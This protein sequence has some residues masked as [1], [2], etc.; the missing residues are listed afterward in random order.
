MDKANC[1]AGVTGG[2]GG[3]LEA[4]IELVEVWEEACEC[5]EPREHWLVVED[6]EMERAMMR[7][8]SGP[9]T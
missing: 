9:V 6:E 7:S 8:R 1:E 3:T 5:T 2:T 4:C